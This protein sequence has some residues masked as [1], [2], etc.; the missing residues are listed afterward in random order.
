[1]SVRNCAAQIRAL[2]TMLHPDASSK[3]LSPTTPVILSTTSMNPEKE[4]SDLYKIEIANKKLAEYNQIL[5]Q[6]LAEKTQ[7]LEKTLLELKKVEADLIQRDKMSSLGQ[8]VAGV[9]HEINNPINFIYG[10]LEYADRYTE[11]MLS[12]LKLYQQLDSIAP[13]IQ[14]KSEAIELSFMIEDLPKIL[15][16]MKIGANR[17]RE[18]ILSLKNFSRMEESE[19][20]Y[21][22]IHAGIDNTLMILQHRFKANRDQSQ[23]EVCKNYG[24]LPLVQC[25]AG[26]L[27]QVFM[28]ILANAID[29]LKEVKHLEGFSPIISIATQ[30]IKAKTPQ[31]IDLIE[32]K[33]TDNGLGMSEDVQKQLF[34]PF[35]TTKPAGKGTGLG[36][37]ISY[38]IVKEKHGGSLQCVS[39]PGWGTEFVIQIPQK[40]S[41]D[42]FRSSD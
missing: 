21:V 4:I 11:D 8:L 12:L 2:I 29:A 10:N 5:E 17:I 15:S 38:E 27:N 32:I 28:N 9:A 39:D 33:I 20:K 31:A 35:F 24:D 19:M 13:E 7:Q 16:S 25:Y 34:N 37:S 3:I 42:Q 23:I 41:L 40:H 14:A 26:H 18:I 6:K 1:M 36:M 30:I 22:D